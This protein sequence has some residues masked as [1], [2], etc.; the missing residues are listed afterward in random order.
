MN[1]IFAILAVDTDPA[2][3]AAL[4]DLLRTAGYQTTGVP[5][6]EAAR[7]FLTSSRCDLLITAIRLVAFNGL[8]LVVRSRVCSPTTA[9]IVLSTFADAMDESEARRL[10][11]A[12]MVKPVDPATLLEVVKTTLASPERKRP[13]WGQRFS[14]RP[15]NPPPPL[16]V[17]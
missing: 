15:T 2:A 13:H 7:Q 16:E 12:Y 10:G 17:V 9:S 1:R 6:F 4:V 5:T 3:L 8:H 14:T 11:A